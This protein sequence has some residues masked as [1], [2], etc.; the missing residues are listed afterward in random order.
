MVFLHRLYGGAKPDISAMLQR[1]LRLTPGD[2]IINV[3]IHG[4]TR[5]VDI[6]GP[7]LLGIA[8]GLIFPP[9]FLFIYEPFILDLKSYTVEGD[10]VTY[11][12]TPASPPVPAVTKPIDPMTGLPIEETKKIEYD[13][14]TGLP[15][16]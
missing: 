16:K 12:K 9:F 6:A 8:G 2:A 14:L 4:S 7:I 15:K 3:R 1:Q 5:M 13:P 11:K 10:I